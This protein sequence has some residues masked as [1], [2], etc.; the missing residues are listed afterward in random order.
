[1]LHL[2]HL[3]DVVEVP[4]TLAPA[5]HSD[6]LAVSACLARMRAMPDEFSKRI[7]FSKFVVVVDAYY[8]INVYFLV[9]LVILCCSNG[10]DLLKFMIIISYLYF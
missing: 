10:S 8:N 9:F 7:V 2:G 1:M 3:T 4:L 5:D 6:V